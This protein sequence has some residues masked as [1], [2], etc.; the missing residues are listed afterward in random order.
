MFAGIRIALAWALLI[1]RTFPAESVMTTPTRVQEDVARELKVQPDEVVILKKYH[2]YWIVKVNNVKY[3]VYREDFSPPVMKLFRLALEAGIGPKVRGSRT[4]EQVPGHLLGKNDLLA[5]EDIRKLA[6]LMKRVHVLQASGPDQVLSP[7]IRGL[8][9]IIAG[10]D[11]KFYIIDFMRNRREDLYTALGWLFC[12]FE[13]FG[14][15][16]VTFL[17]EYM[18]RPPTNEEIDA[19]ER[20][21]ATIVADLVAHQFGV[22]SA[23]H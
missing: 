6:V 21:K 14:Q 20:A 5:D 8:I 12:R 7:G 17:T 23:N 10:D 11:G 15:R 3:N 19:I 18:G 16:M 13:F 22:R 4:V 1:L 2:N 9:K